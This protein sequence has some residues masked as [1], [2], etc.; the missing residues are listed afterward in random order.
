M[1]EVLYADEF[2]RWLDT[3]DDDEIDSVLYALNILAQL[4]PQLGR[5]Y[6]D[7]L[8]DSTISNLKELRIQ[9]N[10]K[11]YRAFYAFDPIR[12]AIML[13]AGDKTG[14]KRFYQRMVPLAERIYDEYL[15]DNEL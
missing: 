12:R 11:P 15:K 8:Y 13:C 14:D 9:H 6:A 1:W 3:L 4:G 10:G 7:T 5:P 2:A